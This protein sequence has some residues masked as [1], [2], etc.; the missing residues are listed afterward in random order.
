M[1]GCPPTEGLPIDECRST[2]RMHETHLAVH[3]L[4][5]YQGSPFL[6]SDGPGR[7]AMGCRWHVAVAFR[8]G[9]VTRF[10]SR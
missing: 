6:S 7:S 1:A 3:N 10:S 5:F 8:G 4:L 2:R 9:Q